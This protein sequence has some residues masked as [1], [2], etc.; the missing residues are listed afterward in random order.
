MMDKFI[1][2]STLKLSLCSGINSIWRTCFFWIRNRKHFWMES[3]RHFP[4]NIFVRQVLDSSYR[5][6]GFRFGPDRKTAIVFYILTVMAEVITDVPGCCSRISKE[7]TSWSTTRG[8][9]MQPSRPCSDLE[10]SQQ[11]CHERTELFPISTFPE[12]QLTYCSLHG[13]RKHSDMVFMNGTK[14]ASLII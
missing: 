2:Y 5:C 1:F 13:W 12:L 4:P 8:Y 6:P 7:E 11:L 10:A 14:L 9:P 3:W